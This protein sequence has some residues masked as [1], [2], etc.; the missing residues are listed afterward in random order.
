MTGSNTVFRMYRIC[1]Y[2]IT[3]LT[4]VLAPA[5]GTI[6]RANSARSIKWTR[7]PSI[8]AVGVSIAYDTSGACSTSGGALSGQHSLDVFQN[9]NYKFVHTFPAAPRM[10][11]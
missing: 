10:R 3:A 4:Q 7:S 9:F 8:E 11:N 2:P 1:V 5:A 6:L